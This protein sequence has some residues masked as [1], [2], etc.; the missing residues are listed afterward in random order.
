MLE[1]I[2][3]ISFLDY[4]IFN[5]LNPIQKLNLIFLS[6]NSFN[7]T[8][9]DFIYLIYQSKNLNNEII[10]T[11]TIINKSDN[12]F[13]NLFIS[14]FTETNCYLSLK[15]FENFTNANKK[16]GL[17]YYTKELENY[18][19][20]Q[21]LKNF[22]KFNKIIDNISFWSLYQKIV[23]L[24]HKIYIGNK[25]Q[26]L[27]K[28]KIFDLENFS[29]FQ[30]LSL[31]RSNFLIFPESKEIITFLLKK[32]ESINSVGFNN[33][34]AYN[35]INEIFS[36]IKKLSIFNLISNGDMMRICL[37]IEKLFVIFSLIRNSIKSISNTNSYT[38]TINSFWMKESKF[39]SIIMKMLRYFIFSY[40]DRLIFNVISNKEKFP[41]LDSINSNNCL[42]IFNKTELGR[43]IS[44][45]S[46]RVTNI[47]KTHYY[48]KI[49]SNE[50]IKIMRNC[51]KVFEYFLCEKDDYLLKLEKNLNDGKFYFFNVL[52][53]D[54]ND[55]KYKKYCDEKDQIE[56]AYMKFFSF[57][58]NFEEVLEKINNSLDNIFNNNVN[59]NFNK[60]EL[61]LI[62]KSKYFF[63]LSKIF[64]IK[65]LKK[66]VSNENYL[67]EKN[68]KI[69]DKIFLFYNKFIENSSDNSLLIMNE[70]IFKSLTNAPIFYGK[71]NFDLFLKCLKYIEKYEKII[72]FSSHYIKNLYEYLNELSHFKYNE[73]NYCLYVFL[74]C[75]DSLILNTKS[76]YI[77]KTVFKTQFYIKKIDMK[78][79]IHENFCK[80]VDDNKYLF[81]YGKNS[82][83]IVKM[84]MKMMLKTIVIIRKII[85]IIMM[86]MIVIV[87][88]IL[89][90]KILVIM[91]ILV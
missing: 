36:V 23:H 52:N 1:K 50:Y 16:T 63:S 60:K 45:I 72:S 21:N 58:I 81:V 5:L 24:F 39:F 73:I 8:Y 48:E 30:R 68:K 31:F 77:E 35:L 71:K 34:E 76:Y 32:I 87:K 88:I 70:Y 15:I 29:C 41:N 79:K 12:L 74:Q 25:T 86:K 84:M 10:S 61:M 28:Y 56:N 2:N 19:T 62:V 51:M 46:L 80:F 53:V 20:F 17:R 67:N 9:K 27:D 69:F 26:K 65:N 33:S 7:D 38:S 11:Y 13:L 89:I 54:V 43:L 37:E 82:K 3:K 78:F 64:D 90:L 57:E 91:K 66:K 6:K 14:N 85:I 83:I 18:F 40:N 75:L 22:F 49:G 59:I 44:R 47:L 4:D 55:K 42:F